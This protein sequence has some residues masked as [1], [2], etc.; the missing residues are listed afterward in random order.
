MLWIWLRLFVFL[1]S[2]PEFDP[3][4]IPPVTN[5]GPEFDP[6]G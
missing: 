2:G 1:K 6:L 4:G 5:A 3:L